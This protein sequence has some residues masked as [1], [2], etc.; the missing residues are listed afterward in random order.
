DL[1][2]PCEE[3]LASSGVGMAFQNF[4]LFPHM[5]AFDNI[6][7]PRNSAST[8]VMSSPPIRILPSSGSMTPAIMRSS[9]VLPAPDGPNSTSVSPSATLSDRLSRTVWLL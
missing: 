7:T 4:A 1:I 2:A 9:T 5:S 8:S 3:C 6:A